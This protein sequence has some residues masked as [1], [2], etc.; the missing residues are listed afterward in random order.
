MITKLELS[1]FSRE[2]RNLRYQYAIIAKAPKINK[3]AAF[4]LGSSDT[5]KSVNWS[6]FENVAFNGICANYHVSLFKFTVLSLA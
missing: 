4:T 2:V 5:K 6:S 3:T 1:Q